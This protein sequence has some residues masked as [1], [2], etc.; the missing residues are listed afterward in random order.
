MKKVVTFFLIISIFV[1]TVYAGVGDALDDFIGSN[2][3][4]L[5]NVSDPRA[6]KV[7][8]RMGVFGGSA[9]IRIDNSLPPLVSFRQ[10]ELRVS[11]SGLDFNAGFLS[12]LNIDM[13]QKLLEQGGTSLVWGLMIGLSYSLPTVANVFEKIQKIV[14]LVQQLS[15]NICNLSMQIG[16]NIA[17]SITEGYKHN[18]SA[19]D[20]ASGSVGTMT[21]AVSKFWDDPDG[22]SKRT[23]G[24]LVYDAVVESGLSSNYA[25]L[26]MSLFGTLEWFPADGSC[27]ISSPEKSDVT[28]IVKEPLVNNVNDFKAFIYGGSLKKYKCGS[29]CSA[30]GLINATCNNLSV[31][32]DGSYSGIK[33]DIFNSLKTVVLKI[34]NGEALSET[35]ESLLAIKALPNTADVYLFLAT[36][37]LKD[38]NLTLLQIDTLADYYAWWIV[39]AVT[40]Y[41]ERAV[42]MNVSKVLARHKTPD[43]IN[44]EY[45]DMKQNLIL[46]RGD[47]HDYFEKRREEVIN[48]VKNMQEF[49]TLRRMKA[50]I[51]GT[52]MQG[53]FNRTLS[54]YSY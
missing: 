4:I 20:I 3:N 46:L 26:A 38:P 2:S 54:K 25:D 21:E 31:I 12:I 50:D 29:N 5:S 40:T 33:N 1:N 13:I 47:I 18:K 11:C 19:R 22:F 17:E 43:K 48:M 53:K 24:N 9:S 7:G 39:E 15:G 28:V 8:N 51:I 16:Q 52:T 42:N 35:D 37:Y 34:A 10:P 14:R 27:N 23:R 44:K 30:A 36:N 45:N 49:E 32:S 41:A 6:F